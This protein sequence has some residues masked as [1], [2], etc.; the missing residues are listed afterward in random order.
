[1]S[2]KIGNGQ[3]MGKS[4]REVTKQKVSQTYF[5]VVSG[6]LVFLTLLQDHLSLVFR[7]MNADLDLDL[8]RTH[9]VPG[10][11]EVL[12]SQFKAQKISG[13]PF[14]ALQHS[15]FRRQSNS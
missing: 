11:E 13:S 2:Y 4:D 9:G 1:M 5:G 3:G 12:I 14:I 6:L 7:C 10:D 8:L 15:H